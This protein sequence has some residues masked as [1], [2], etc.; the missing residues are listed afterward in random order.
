MLCWIPYF[1]VHNVRIHSHYCIKVPRALIVFAETAALLNSAVNPIFYGLFNVNIR[2]GICDILPWACGCRRRGCSADSSQRSRCC[3]ASQAAGVT[4][5]SYTVGGG[6]AASPT[7]KKTSW[8]CKR[9]K[10]DCCM[11]ILKPPAS[12]TNGTVAAAAEV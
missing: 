7:E 3:D 1:A 8:R 5:C 11:G 4:S 6:S 12:T 9:R 2:R 10:L